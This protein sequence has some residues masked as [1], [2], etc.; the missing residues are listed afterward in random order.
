MKIV[1]K[2]NIAFCYVDK[3][4]EA[5]SNQIKDL[6]DNIAFAGNRIAIMPDAHMGKGSCIG[7][8]YKI[9]DKV[10]PN[11]VG[12]D[13]GCLD[14]ETE[15]LSPSGWLKISEY[16]GEKVLQY[17]KETDIASFTNP[18]NFINEEATEFYH[19][20]NSKGLDQI[21]SE[22]HKVLI[23]KGSK[24][25]GYILEDFSVPDLFKLQKEDKLS[26]GYYSIKSS[27]ELENSD[28][29]IEDNNI[30]IDVMIA[31]NGIIRVNKTKSYNKCELHFKKERK[32]ARAKEL[33]S[34]SNI[35][36]D[37][38]LGKD[39]T[40]YI[41]FKIDKSINKSLKK[42]FNASKRQLKIVADESLLWDGHLGERSF[43]SSTDKTNADLVQYA[44]SAN[45]IRAGISNDEN[46]K[47]EH[48]KTNNIV[49][50]TKNT[51]IGLTNIEKLEVEK[52]ERK[53]C[54][55]VPNG[56]FIIRRNGRISI[57]GNCGVTAVK[58]ISKK[59]ELD[60]SEL[61]KYIRAKI[62]MGFSI[63]NSVS[64]NLENIYNSMNLDIN[65]SSYMDSLETLCNKIEVDFQ[66]VK[67][68][69]GTLGGGNHFIELDED[70]KTRDVWLTIHTGSRNLGLKVAQ[71]HQNVAERNFTKIDLRENV[72]ILK[73][74]FK[75]IELNNKIKELKAD[76]LSKVPNKGFEYLE[77]ANLQSYLK[78]LNIAQIYAELNRF[79]II[80]EITNRYSK[81]SGSMI[82]STHNYIDKDSFIRKGAISAH[83]GEKVIIPLSMADGVIIGTGKGNKDWNYSAPHGAG[84][85]F[86]RTKA[87]NILSLDDMKEKMKD[88]FST[89]ICLETLDESPEA[90]KDSKMI[91]EYL[92]PTVEIENVLI[93]VYNIKD[94]TKRR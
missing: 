69:I 93:P 13:I 51:N 56:Y 53:Y 9:N 18:E 14:K 19:F 64:N 73:S 47:E 70:K 59:E 85:L 15:F 52:G 74:Q 94:D 58:L 11:V 83:K 29:K 5:T 78:D 61:D 71:Y 54:F 2:E 17:N 8:T 72:L 42:Y 41:F 32:I 33:L 46:T 12:V 37:E 39:K 27:F 34:N 24:T 26:K 79:V 57:T 36:F 50:P 63:R 43:F 86:S 68:S 60:F 6:T 35:L 76:V 91:I 81:I 31:A 87:R 20:K 16:N 3:L 30:K 40:T 84:R 45:N 90:Y 38:T 44:F 92:K 66:R 28:I 62:P 65:F 7:F 89:S 25:R 4:D 22:E 23:W 1:G 49:T 75:G 82:K 21:V 48:W 77:G 55:T 67:K 88:V 80:D 10:I